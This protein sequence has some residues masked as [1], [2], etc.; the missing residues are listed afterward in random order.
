MEEMRF[1]PLGS[2]SRLCFSGQV[3][4]EI[5]QKMKSEL[6]DRLH[7]MDDGSMLICDLSQVTFLDSSGIGLLVFLNNKMHQKGG[8]CCLYQPSDIVRFRYMG[9]RRRSSVSGL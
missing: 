1:E 4:Y 3:T 8:C 5:I 2:W 6:E 7:Q 9:A